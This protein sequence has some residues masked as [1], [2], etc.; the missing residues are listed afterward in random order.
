MFPAISLQ[1][2]WRA[3][4]RVGRKSR[5]GHLFINIASRV[6]FIHCEYHFQLMMNIDTCQVLFVFIPCVCWL[7]LALCVLLRQGQRF[8]I[9]ENSQHKNLSFK[10]N[11]KFWCNEVWILKLESDFHVLQIISPPST[12]YQH[13]MQ[14]FVSISGHYAWIGIKQ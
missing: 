13:I 1:F 11:E 5:E 3:I 6:I 8:V 4:R 12:Y 14:R 10:K 2:P 7:N 9:R